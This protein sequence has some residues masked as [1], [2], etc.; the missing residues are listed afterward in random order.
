MFDIC[1]KDKVRNPDHVASRCGTHPVAGVSAP[2]STVTN[3][4]SGVDLLRKVERMPVAETN[5]MGVPVK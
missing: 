1:L 2:T 3:S 5:F 4:P